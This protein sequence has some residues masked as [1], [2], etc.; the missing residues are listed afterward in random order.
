MLFPQLQS[1]FFIIFLL[2]FNINI[3]IRFILQLITVVEHFNKYR[4]KVL[5]LTRKHQKKLL[6]FK[7]IQKQASVFFVDNL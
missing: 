2:L 4:K 5:V 3:N 1:D 6:Q 7:Q